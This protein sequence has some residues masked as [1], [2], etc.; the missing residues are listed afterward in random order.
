MTPIRALFSSLRSVRRVA[1][2]LCFVALLLTSAI[3]VADD[4]LELP[5]PPLD[6]FSFDGLTLPTSIA[7]L[8]AQYPAAMSDT[9]A[10]EEK[11]GL[12]CYLVKHLPS[13][14]AARISNHRQSR[15]Y[16]EGP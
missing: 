8:K 4:P 16:E 14:D 1:P 9:L 11:L 12:T 6:R 10:A 7:R 15:W 13:A 2:L 3:V 5:R